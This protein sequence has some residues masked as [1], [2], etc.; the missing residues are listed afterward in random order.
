MPFR[1]IDIM[2]GNQE[3]Q[4]RPIEWDTDSNGH[5]GTGMKPDGTY[6]L[7]TKFETV[8]PHCSQLL[9]FYPIN[10][11]VIDKD[12]KLHV[13][14]SNCVKKTKIENPVNDPMAVLYK[15]RT[16]DLYVHD[17]MVRPIEE[18]SKDVE[19]FKEKMSRSL[20]LPRSGQLDSLFLDPI[21]AGL[22]KL[23]GAVLVA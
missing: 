4:A 5:D 20:N 6:M 3:I 15:L 9:Q 7:P 12:N 13:M 14:C 17:F 1:R 23:E 8:C 11:Q 16:I 18:N 2:V 10:I 21:E 19:F 22:M